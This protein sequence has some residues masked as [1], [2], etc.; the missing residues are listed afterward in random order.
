MTAASAGWPVKLLSV[1]VVI[2]YPLVLHQF[3]LKN[4]SGVVGVGLSIIPLILGVLWQIRHSR[5]RIMLA[6]GIIALTLLGLY[7]WQIKLIDFSAAYFL[8]HVLMY[9]ALMA[10]FGHTLLPGRQALI[11]RLALGIHG[12]DLPPEI[13]RYTRQITWVWT[14]FFAATA[15][16]SWLLYRYATLDVW[17]WFANV[18]SLPLSVALFVGEYWFRLRRFPDFDHIPLLKGIQ[19]MVKPDAPKRPN[20]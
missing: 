15:L 16:L 14:L 5:H 9:L 18:M 7:A 3:V 4:A 11:T 19:V 17:S 1:L 2:A 13:I 12:G 6:I 20:A 10:F 8:P